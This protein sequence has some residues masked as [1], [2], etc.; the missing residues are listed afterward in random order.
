MPEG[1]AARLIRCGLVGPK[2]RPQG[3][4]DGQ[5]LIFPYRCAAVMSDG[6]TQGGR[7]GVASASKPVGS[8]GRQ[9]RRRDDRGVMGRRGGNAQAARIEPG[10]PR[11]ASSQDV[12]ATVPQTDTG[13]L[14]E[15][16]KVDG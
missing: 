7:S 5:R 6:G 11:K 13:G 2:P 4:G 15:H 3:V 16:T 1:S 12:R 10:L 8:A 14:V 9:I